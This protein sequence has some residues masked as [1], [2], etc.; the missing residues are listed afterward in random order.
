M[1]YRIYESEM[2]F[3][4]Q[5]KVFYTLGSFEMSIP[6]VALKANQR[7]ISFQLQEITGS[8][9]AISTQEIFEA[10]EIHQNIKIQ[11]SSKE[12]EWPI[13]VLNAQVS[14]KTVDGFE[15]KIFSALLVSPPA[16]FLQ[17]LDEK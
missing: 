10:I 17:L 8:S 3:H 9:N 6:V 16:E 14:E 5:A 13:S 12:N 15:N 11:L 7:N 4:R 2:G 1:L